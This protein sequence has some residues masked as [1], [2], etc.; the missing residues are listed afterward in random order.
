MRNLKDQGSGHDLTE[1]TSLEIPR[2]ASMP[3]KHAHVGCGGHLIEAG[4]PKDLIGNSYW[5]KSVLCGLLV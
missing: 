1:S 3:T 5:Q 2:A 4:F